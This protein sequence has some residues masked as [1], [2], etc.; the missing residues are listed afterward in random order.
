MCLFYVIK[1]NLI[2]NPKLEIQLKNIDDIEFLI[3]FTKYLEGVCIPDF[4]FIIK[5]EKDSL[6]QYIKM[7]LSLI[8]TI[9]SFNISECC[10]GK[11]VISTLNLWLPKSVNTIL[12]SRNLINNDNLPLLFNNI[13]FN[14]II[15]LDLS[16]NKSISTE[17]IKAI[18]EFL[19][20]NNTLNFLNLSQIKIG[21]NGFRYISDSLKR[22]SSLSSLILNC[23]FIEDGISHVCEAFEKSKTLKYLDIQQNYFKI[24]KN[25]DLLMISLSKN[26]SIIG[27]NLRS[28]DCVK[29][30]F[31]ETINL[32][33]LKKDLK[34]LFLGKNAL[35]DPY[36]IKIDSS[37]Q[38]L[39]G[40]LYELTSLD[41]ENNNISGEELFF[42]ALFDRQ[43]K[44]LYLNDNNFLSKGY[45]NLYQFLRKNSSLSMIDLSKPCV[46]FKSYSFFNFLCFNTNLKIFKFNF[47][48]IN[49]ENLKFIG[50][51]IIQNS[52]L[53]VLELNTNL[54]CLKGLINLNDRIKFN[55]TLKEV[56]ITLNLIKIKNLEIKI[57]KRIYF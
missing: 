28:I 22:N 45:E 15:N 55:K 50:E 44:V 6:S 36:N 21:E 34:E 13:Q 53:E 49:S 27:L 38:R 32:L 57:D 26:T 48:P 20:N 8:Q 1:E 3:K 56:N 54:I 30:N 12:L 10:V 43:I 16:K 46:N 47:S 51:C 33:C 7:N 4:E 9:T 24:S 5:F 39:F 40:N 41:L 35:L 37:L 52:C 19:N 17:G 18:C 14:K 42:P 11:S 2:F 25:F 23:T 29:M 31:E